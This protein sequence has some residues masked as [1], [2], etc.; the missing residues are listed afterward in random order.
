M[1]QWQVTGGQDVYPL[2][3]TTAIIRPLFRDVIVNLGRACLKSARPSIEIRGKCKFDP[4]LE[5]LEVP[6]P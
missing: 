3:T 2:T 4:Y 6:V 1:I 5:V